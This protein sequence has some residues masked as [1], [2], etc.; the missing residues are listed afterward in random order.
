[1]KTIRCLLTLVSVL[2]FTAACGQD[3]GS[4]IKEYK[5]TTTQ[6]TSQPFTIDSTLCNDEQGPN[7]TELRLGDDYLTTSR[8]AKGYLYSC[9]DKNPSAP[10]SI[11]SKITWINF[12]DKTWNFL[13]KL[14]LP[15]GTFSPTAGFYSEATSGDKRQIN[16]N[17]LPV[18][19]KIGDWPMTN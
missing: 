12:S 15:P 10:G 16:V 3:D 18:D 11:E 14:W 6:P 5:S 7:C 17:N 8:P 9:V 19:G 13:E 4:P 2:V 1:M